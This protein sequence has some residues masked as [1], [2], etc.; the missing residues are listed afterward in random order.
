VVMLQ[1]A[2][3]RRTGKSTRS[4]NELAMAQTWLARAVNSR[5]G[6]EALSLVRQALATREE[7]MVRAGERND[8]GAGFR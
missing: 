5:S 8:T 1:E 2:L 3:I 6:T 7:V 4:L